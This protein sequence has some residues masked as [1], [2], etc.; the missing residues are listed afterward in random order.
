MVHHLLRE[1][2]DPPWYLW[3]LDPH[4]GDDDE[5][6]LKPIAFEYRRLFLVTLY[7]ILVECMGSHSQRT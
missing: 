1:I 3:I 6:P 7:S 5:I 2:L 4:N